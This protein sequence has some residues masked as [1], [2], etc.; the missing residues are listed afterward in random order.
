MKEKEKNIYGIHQYTLSSGENQSKSKKTKRM[1]RAEIR[2]KSFT[3]LKRVHTTQGCDADQKGR[4]RGRERKAAGPSSIEKFSLLV[5]SVAAETMTKRW[6]NDGTACLHAC[7]HSHIKK[8]YCTQCKEGKGADSSPS[9]SSSFLFVSVL[10]PHFS[11]CLR[12]I[13]EITPLRY[14]TV[15]AL[16]GYDQKKNAEK[17]KTQSA[18]E[19][20]FSLFSLYLSLSLSLFLCVCVC[21]CADYGVGGSASPC[22][23]KAFSSARN[24][25][26]QLSL[27]LSLFLSPSLSLITL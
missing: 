6:R 16:I 22:V 24:P 7:M 13:L 25:S 17:Y 1:K 10:S 18:L 27:L 9:L 5:I 15:H 4:R 20:S 2:R 23:S 11:Y 3:T 12:V 26:G 19:S 21:V 14:N 8:E